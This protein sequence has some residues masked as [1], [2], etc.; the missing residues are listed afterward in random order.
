MGYTFRM[1]CLH[2]GAKWS[3]KY[4]GCLMFLSGRRERCSHMEGELTTP[5]DGAKQLPLTL[6]PDATHGPSSSS[7]D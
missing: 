1:R 5:E 3:P 7:R 6:G 4:G 2:T